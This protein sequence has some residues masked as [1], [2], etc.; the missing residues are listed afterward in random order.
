MK[1]AVSNLIVI[2]L[3]SVAT[4]A[5]LDNPRTTAAAADVIIPPYMKK[6]YNKMTQALN[7]DDQGISAKYLSSLQT[8]HWLDPIHGKR[9]ATV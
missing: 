8:I 2:S 3:I 1:L 5:P 6:I 7:Q 4:T 9:I